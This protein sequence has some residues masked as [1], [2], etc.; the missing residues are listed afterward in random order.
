MGDPLSEHIQ[1]PEVSRWWALPLALTVAATG[2]LWDPQTSSYGT[3]KGVALPLGGLATVVAAWLRV[4]RGASWD[5]G[6]PLVAVL[7]LVVWAGLS[8]WWTPSAAAGLADLALVTAAVTLLLAGRVL[9]QGEGAARVLATAM[10]GSGLVASMVALAEYG[11]GHRLILG[12]IGNPN[13][14]A[15]YVAATGPALVWVAWSWG[16]RAEPPPGWRLLRLGRLAALLV[17]LALPLATI[18]LTGCRSAWLAVGAGLLV[19]V[20]LTRPTRR[21]RWLAL[22][23]TLAL[24]LILGG[25]ATR[26][27]GPANTFRGPKPASSQWRQR[28]EGRIYLAR[29]STKLFLARAA[30]GHGVGSFALRFPEYQAARLAAH[31]E[32]RSLWTNAHTAH[33]EPLQVLVELGLVGGLLMIVI[34]LLAI[35]A[36]VGERSPPPSRRLVAAA[37]L[38][39]LG[40]AGLAEGSLHT[41]ALLTL[42]TASA[43]LLWEPGASRVGALQRATWVAAGVGV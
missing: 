21:S 18:W 32:E 38:T 35:V 9:L 25:V 1:R 30:K 31:P 6:G 15:I 29:I 20:A 12:T 7:G 11:L 10:A 43:A 22:G 33:F 36:M 42:A 16:T 26:G 23:A 19:T 41:V 8:L 28:L 40:V 5:L 13:H 24:C 39:I 14:L 37:S 4:Q 27:L 34:T 2:I 3:L 17:L